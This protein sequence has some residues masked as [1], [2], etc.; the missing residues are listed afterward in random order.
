MSRAS[1]YGRSVLLGK[2]ESASDRRI[3]S[4][5]LL[6]IGQIRSCHSRLCGTDPVR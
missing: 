6:E 2:I 1:R 3:A 4:G 5:Q